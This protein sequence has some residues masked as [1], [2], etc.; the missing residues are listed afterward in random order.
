[1]PANFREGQKD[2]LIAKLGSIMLGFMAA[3]ANMTKGL[4][5]RT[6]LVG[7]VTIRAKI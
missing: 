4:L 3:N 7:P 6:Q 1:L 5:I 2:L